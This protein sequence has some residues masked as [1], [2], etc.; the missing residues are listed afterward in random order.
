LPKNCHD[1]R[2]CLNTCFSYEAYL[3]LLLFWSVSFFVVSC[4]FDIVRVGFG[5]FVLF[6]VFWYFR[7]LERVW[8]VV[9]VLMCLS[10]WSLIFVM[11]WICRLCWPSL[12]AISVCFP[13]GPVTKANKKRAR[14]K[15]SVQNIQKCRNRRRRTTCIKNNN[16]TKTSKNS[17]NNT[18][19]H[20]TMQNNTRQPNMSEKGM[21]D[22]KQQSKT[23]PRNPKTVKNNAKHN[24]TTQNSATQQPTTTKRNTKQSNVT[25]TY[26]KVLFWT[27]VCLGADGC[28]G[29]QGNHIIPYHTISYQTSLY[30]A[31]NCICINIIIITQL[32]LILISILFIII[33]L[34]LL[35]IL[36]LL[37][38]CIL[39]WY[40]IL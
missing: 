19:Q 36:V 15:N 11:F 39:S 12:R 1:A 18:N 23:T 7:L 38:C 40:I 16:N 27:V 26:S 8:I 31:N 6:Y 3:L 34:L 14:T 35:L 5:C 10:F 29:V 30:Y 22:F 37:L 21:T 9:I 2:Q 33:L 32:M 4:V 24:N 13:H 17:P 25:Q 28:D 20:T